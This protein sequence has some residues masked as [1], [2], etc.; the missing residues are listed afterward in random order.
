MVAPILSSRL[1]LRRFPIFLV[2]VAIGA[3]VLA[4]G[5]GFRHDAARGAGRDYVHILV[6]EPSTLDPAAAG[7]STSAALAGQLYETLTSFDPSLT[8]RPALAASWLV[9]DDGLRVVFTMRPGLTFSDGSPLTAA[10]VVRSWLRVI[11]P[12]AP[13]PLA[14][15]LDE[16]VG[17]TA[18]RRGESSDPG[19]VGI[20]AVD[21]LMVEV[22]LEQPAG[23]FPSIVASPTFGV[24]PP[25]MR[26]GSD[27]STLPVSGGYRLVSSAP[28]ELLLQA[29]ERYWAGR[30]AIETVHLVT[31]IGG[32]SPVEAFAA[33]EV[34]YTPISSFDASWI[35]YDPTLGPAL[36]EV[37]SLFVTYFGFDTGRPPFDDVRVRRAFAAAVDWRRIAALG[38]NGQASPANSMVPPGIPG[39]SDTDWLPAHDASTART[40]LADAGYPNG[41]GF[42]AVTMITFGTGYE[43]AI[44]TELR[45]TLGVDI[46]YESMGGDDYFS[47]VE[48]DPP[49]IWAMS[50]V[51]DYPGPN[52]FLGLLLGTGKTANYGRWSSPAFDAAIA[53]ALGA[54]DAVTARAA[55][56]RAEAIVRDDA[57]VVPV[58]YGTGWALSADGLLGAGQNGLSIIRMAGLAWND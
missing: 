51:A 13:S 9:E 58:S 17:A 25:G 14:S 27:V 24:V 57:P 38:A 5:A 50:W 53:D 46:A 44:V 49:A 54:S 33:G 18:Y 34:D 4:A 47:R 30:P 43:E 10:D 32:R 22:R 55:F 52:D 41:L 48:D 2:A 28:T 31:D 12:A 1:A 29:N 37:P 16:V 21:D 42:P 7:D 40:L 39:S 20:R 26:L 11:D 23:D 15:L 45:D 35:A 19:T 3:S 56:D 36:R 6:G 8:L